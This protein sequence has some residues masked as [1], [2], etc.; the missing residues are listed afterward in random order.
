MKTI[1]WFSPLPPSET[2]IANF[3]VRVARELQRLCNLTLWTDKRDLKK[4]RSTLGLSCPIRSYTDTERAITDLN[5]ADAIFFNFGNN[6][7]FHRDIWTKSKEFSGCAILHDL[8][9]FEFGKSIYNKSLGQNTSLALLGRR[10]YGQTTDQEIRQAF[11]DPETYDVA[12]KYPFTQWLISGC[13][14][15]IQHTHP[16]FLESPKPL[17]NE[18]ER[19]IFHAYLPYPSTIPKERQTA[20]RKESSPLHCLM[21]GYIGGDNRRLIPILEAL[22]RYPHKDKIRLH[23]AGK[24]HPRFAVERRLKN[25][26][27]QHLVTLHGFLNENG[28]DQLIRNTDLVINLRYPSRGESSGSLLRAWNQEACCLVTNYGYY[29]GLPENTVIKTAIKNEA[30]D[31]HAAWDMLLKN[32]HMGI[33]YGK[34]GKNFLEEKHSVEDYVAAVLKIAEFPINERSKPTKDLLRQRYAKWLNKSMDNEEVATH[35]A[36]RLENII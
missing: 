4:K 8:S 15:A 6:A 7:A 19:P 11:E 5:R 35:L 32:P 13:W 21:F 30:A 1:H 9:L 16:D 2:D 20:M 3:S 25:M 26:G 17:L 18:L 36:Q 14:G 22:Y 29:E 33:K 23:L 12:E 10:I 24:I 34:E 27:I 28:L 31:I